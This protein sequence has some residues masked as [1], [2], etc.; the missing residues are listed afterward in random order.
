M[1]V[2]RDPYRLTREV[3]KRVYYVVK[4]YPRMVKLA[5]ALLESSSSSEGP[6][7]KGSISDSTAVKAIKRETLLEQ[8]K[9]IDK[10]LEFIPE[11][12]RKPIW[13]NI[14]KDKMYPDYADRVTFWRYRRKFFWYVADF[15][16]II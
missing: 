5:D 15:L 4:D 11:E 13:D 6:A 16:H 14:Q 3:Y 2:R 9:A 7:A 1:G 10:A 8:I 12:Y